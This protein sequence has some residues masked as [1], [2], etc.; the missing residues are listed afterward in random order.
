MEVDEALTRL[1]KF[2]RWRAATYCM[3]CASVTVSG[4]WHMMAIVFIGKIAVFICVGVSARHT[5]SARLVKTVRQMFQEFEWGECEN[6][7]VNVLLSS[8]SN[9]C[10]ESFA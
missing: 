2:N 8:S 10:T 1:G 6:C 7:I 3:I 9:M 5:K 4:C